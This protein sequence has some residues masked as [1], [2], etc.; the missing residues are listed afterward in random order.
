MYGPV[1]G[2][3]V[4]AVRFVF[5]TCLS[6][7]LVFSFTALVDFV[8]THILNSVLRCVFGW[9]RCSAKIFPHPVS[10]KLAS[11]KY[12]LLS[13]IMKSLCALPHSNADSERVFSLIRKNKTE[14]RASM[15]R[16]MLNDLTVVKMS[17]ISRGEVCHSQKFSPD[18][19]TKVKK[20]SQL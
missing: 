15:S 10:E 17:L 13:S 1:Q 9:L 12:P 8:I 19:L 7:D 6:L 11:L 14:C 16:E 5:V 3:K 2:I 20:L 4:C 18:F